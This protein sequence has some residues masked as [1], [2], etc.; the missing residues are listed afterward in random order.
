MGT[1]YVC[2]SVCLSVCLLARITRI[3]HGRTSP[4]LLY[5][6]LVAMVRWRCD[7]LWVYGRWRNVRTRPDLIEIFQMVKGLAAVSRS[8]SLTEPRIG[9]PEVTVGSW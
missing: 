3:P 4:K 5:M 7:T 2:S 8:F 9:Q 1:G 6:L